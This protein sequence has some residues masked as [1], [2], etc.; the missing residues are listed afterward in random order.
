M[1]KSWNEKP[2]R[3]TSFVAG[4]N[5]YSS[6]SQ[7]FLFLNLLIHI[8]RLDG[9]KCGFCSFYQLSTS[10][11]ELWHFLFHVQYI[12]R[13]VQNPRF[14]PSKRYVLR[15]DVFF[16]FLLFRTA[17]TGW[18]VINVAW[19]ILRK[20]K[21]SNAFQVFTTR[22]IVSGNNACILNFSNMNDE[23]SRHIYVC[24]Y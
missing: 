18:M 12:N 4:K 20:I 22:Q 2:K 5:L 17:S 16:Q 13:P 21:T 14:R 24:K 11:I 6:I 23:S 1:M 7:P 8:Y 9:Q 3:R 19:L 15:F 10:R